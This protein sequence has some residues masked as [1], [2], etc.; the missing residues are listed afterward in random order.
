MKIKKIKELQSEFSTELDKALEKKNLIDLELKGIYSYLN[1]T[2]SNEI[3]GPAF[4]PNPFSIFKL[5]IYTNHLELLKSA[6]NGYLVYDKFEIPVA[7]YEDQLTIDLNKK[8]VQQGFELVKYHNWL[9]NLKVKPSLEKNGQSLNLEQKL[10]ALYLLDINFEDHTN[11]HMAN[12][13]GQILNMDSQ[14][15]RGNLSNIHAGKN[16]IRKIENFEKLAE[17]F[18]NKT[19]DSISTKIKR[20]IKQLK[21]K[22]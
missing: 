16:S 18:K 14:N 17:L 21:Q 11:S 10:L 1:P 19:F 7:D 20:E 22:L 12:V 15:I 13:L 9:N 2:L 8:I 5:E 6:F 3:F 4:L